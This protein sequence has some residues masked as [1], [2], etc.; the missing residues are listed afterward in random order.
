MLNQFENV[1]CSCLA[2]KWRTHVQLYDRIYVFGLRNQKYRILPLIQ[3]D[4][5]VAI[6]INTVSTHLK[7]FQ[8]IKRTARKEHFTTN[9][10]SQLL[11]LVQL[12]TD[13]QYSCTF[14]THTRKQQLI[15][16]ISFWIRV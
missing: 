10:L 2:D 1:Q 16:N 4:V 12:L 15:Y 7:W 3:I 14:Y 9:I 13:V 8:S 5:V 6:N 11:F